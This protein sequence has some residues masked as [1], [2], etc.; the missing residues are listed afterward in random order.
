[1]VCLGVRSGQD[2]AD[3]RPWSWEASL[4]PWAF[5]GV[6]EG[7]GGAHLGQG[8]GEDSP[9]ITG[10]S[11]PL[12]LRDGSPSHCP[13]SFGPLGK[14]MEPAFPSW[15]AL[16]KYLTV[17]G[18]KEGSGLDGLW[19]SLEKPGRG[20]GRAHGSRCPHGSPT[21]SSTHHLPPSCTLTQGAGGPGD[22]AGGRAGRQRRT[23][24]GIHT[25]LRLPVCLSPGRLSAPPARCPSPPSWLFRQGLLELVT[26]RLFP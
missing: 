18:T 9:T 26:S 20:E 10:V 23:P 7:K 13:P 21:P 16:S 14:L 12:P 6:E 15:G 2:P 4:A 1:M 8:G 11:L 25:R 22:R 5:Q 17:G 3:S 24:L 19:L